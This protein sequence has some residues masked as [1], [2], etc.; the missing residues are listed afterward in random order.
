M[1]RKAVGNAGDRASG[2][3]NES[4][5]CT[6]SLSARSKAWEGD[7]EEELRGETDKDDGSAI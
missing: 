5:M 2:I 6:T 7:G 1:R 4:V 3:G